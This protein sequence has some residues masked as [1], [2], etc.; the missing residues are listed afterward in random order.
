MID[1]RSNAKP[2][3]QCRDF[4]ERPARLRKL[5]QE[6][7]AGLLRRWPDPVRSMGDRSNNDILRRNKIS[8]K[9]KEISQ[10]T[11][12]YRGD[13]R[14]HFDNGFSNEGSDSSRRLASRVAQSELVLGIIKALD[15]ES[16]RF[17][18]RVRT[19]SPV[20]KLEDTHV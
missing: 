7:V 12:T 3:D 8:G 19:V 6:V 18:N 10:K 16:V 2:N 4:F 14:C 11:K 9:K 20:I 13:M 5:A 1:R 15:V 17:I